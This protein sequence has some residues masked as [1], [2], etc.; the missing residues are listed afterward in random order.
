MHSQGIFDWR[1][2]F[3]GGTLQFGEYISSSMVKVK[4]EESGS[5]SEEGRYKYIAERD[6]EQF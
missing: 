2:M 4:D 3:S 5:R 6:I 1:D